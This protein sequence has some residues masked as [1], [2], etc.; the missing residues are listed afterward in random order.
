M[1]QILLIQGI[2]IIVCLCLQYSCTP[3]F[4]RWS[5]NKEAVERSIRADSIQRAQNRYEWLTQCRN[6]KIDF[7]NVKGIGD[8][9]LSYLNSLLLADKFQFKTKKDSLAQVKLDSEI[10]RLKEQIYKDKKVLRKL[11]STGNLKNAK[12]THYYI[13]SCSLSHFDR[14]TIEAVKQFTSTNSKTFTTRTK[15]EIDGVDT[16]FGNVIF[17]GYNDH[18]INDTF[19]NIEFSELFYSHGR[20][21]SG[22][23]W[24]YLLK[25]NNDS[26]FQIVGNQFGGYLD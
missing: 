25:K 3:H 21:I 5:D 10:I 2:F 13:D 24:F 19:P 15:S 14:S 4:K 23:I 22:I 8:T 9:L 12:K 6:E 26:T 16:I 1:K 18:S 20:Y 17:I 7:A 11:D